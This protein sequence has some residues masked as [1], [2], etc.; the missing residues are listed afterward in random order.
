[1]FLS[2]DAGSKSIY[3]RTSLP[4]FSN[5]IVFESPRVQACTNVWDWGS[6]KRKGVSSETAARLP[7]TCQSP[8]PCSPSSSPRRQQRPTSP[9]SLSTR[10][11]NTLHAATGHP[12]R[13]L[14]FSSWELRALQGERVP[15]GG[16][17]CSH[18]PLALAGWV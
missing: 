11:A 10:Q 17:G 6:G 2:A 9:L 4:R 7:A 12:H 8:L 14:G 15:P 1:M 5:A 13:P 16:D 18:P 3:K